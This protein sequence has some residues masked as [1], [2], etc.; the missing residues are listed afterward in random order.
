MF[1]LIDNV[2]QSADLRV[3]GLGGGGCSAIQFMIDEGVKGLNFIFAN[4]DQ[5]AL[6]ESEDLNAILIGPELCKGLGAGANPE[7]GRSAAEESRDLIFKK[8]SGADMVFIVAG[9]GGG[10]GSGAMQVIAE[11]ARELSVLTVAVVTTPFEFEGD[12]RRSI[13]ADA[14]EGL[15]SK[16]DAMIQLDN[17]SV[18]RSIGK[19][20]SL[21][22]AFK[23]GN[24]VLSETITSVTDLIQSPGMINIDFSDIRTILSG[25]GIARYGSGTS[26]GEHRAREATERAIKALQLEDIDLGKASGILINITSGLDL[27]LGEFS[28]VGDTIE[29][30]AST[31]AIVVVGTVI[32][33]AMQ[34]KL[35]VGVTAVMNGLVEALPDLE[36]SEVTAA[37][38]K[39]AREATGGDYFDIPAFLR[40]KTDI[41]EPSTNGVTLVVP[42]DFAD[43]RVA[44]L[45]LHLSNVYRSVGGDE[46]VVND[47]GQVPPNPRSS[48][49]IEILKK[50]AS[51]K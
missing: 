43:D 9:F 39:V 11:V 5:A 7:I 31:D 21:L 38:M 30:F 16:V 10:T 24:R 12:K 8:L 34:D 29:E 17:E 3:L 50:S 49:P 20:A 48:Q 46:L 27:S 14:L 6:P 32:D 1:E 36:S 37:K 18:L 4:T 13:A 42:A 41:D 19:N 28:E 33:E 45:V 35:R 47:V 40:N 25:G 15:Q 22:E 44:E 23:E 26:R 51:A 2:P